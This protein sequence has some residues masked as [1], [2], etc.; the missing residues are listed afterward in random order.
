[1]AVKRPIFEY[2][3]DGAAKLANVDGSSTPAIYKFEPAEAY[4]LERM[5]VH[6]EDGGT[7][8]VVTYG[9]IAAL[10]NGIEIGIY[11]SSDDSLVQ[12]LLDG[13]PIKNNGQWARV[14]Y[15]VDILAAL[16]AGNTMGTVRWTFGKSGQPLWIP[17]G[18][19]LGAV[20]NDDLTG[21]TDHTFMVQ[22]Y[23]A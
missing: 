17:E 15:D 10:A 22:G 19:Y 5:I 4:Y 21:L 1:M 16:G 18:Q 6:I 20:I 7:W 9:S 2:L 11:N 12:D 23:P 13:L 8:Q 14:C 3:A